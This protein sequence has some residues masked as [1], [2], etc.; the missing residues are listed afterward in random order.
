MIRLVVVGESKT[1]LSDRETPINLEG[2]VDVYLNSFR[3][4]G[5]KHG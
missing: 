1:S 5:R 4:H 2:I 3:I